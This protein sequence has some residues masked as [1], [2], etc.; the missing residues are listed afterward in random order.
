MKSPVV[1]TALAAMLLFSACSN[2]P[3]F[4]HTV[5]STST[6]TTDV[7]SST[8]SLSDYA[9]VLAPRMQDYGMAVSGLENCNFS[10]AA[11]AVACTINMTTASI[12][13]K[14]IVSSLERAQD[15]DSRSY[16]GPPSAESDRLVSETITQ[17]AAIET[18]YTRAEPC[19]KQPDGVGCQEQLSDLYLEMK[20]FHTW[21]TEKWLPHSS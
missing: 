13:A 1:A 2:G 19:V 14:R 4:P 9:K 12:D 7:S 15:P 11:P 5:T 17:G 10:D 6:A 21:L 20:D 8:A 3:A 18:L 16:V